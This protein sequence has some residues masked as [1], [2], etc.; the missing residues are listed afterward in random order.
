MTPN[1][2]MM[3][4]RFFFLLCYKLAH[5]LSQITVKV[6]TFLHSF[7]HFIP[8]SHS[9]SLTYPLYLRSTAV[10]LPFP[11]PLLHIKIVPVPMLFRSSISQLPSLLSP[12]LLSHPFYLP[13]LSS[14]L[15]PYHNVKRS[16]GFLPISKQRHADFPECDRK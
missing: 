4:L 8:L 16:F 11:N 2:F 15:T 5:H 9:L 13:I 10:P 14:F 6:I 7:A 1:I 3:A 12:V